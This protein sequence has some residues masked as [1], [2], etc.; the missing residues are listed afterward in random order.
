LGIAAFA[1]AAG[2]FLPP[3]PTSTSESTTTATGN[4]L[5]T[6][7]G[8]LVER[9]SILR[10]FSVAAAGAATAMINE[11]E[12]NTAVGLGLGIVG[13]NGTCNFKVLN[14]SAVAGS[15]SRIRMET[16]QPGQYCVQIHDAGDLMEPARFAITIAHS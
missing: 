10:T 14:S 5:E 7:A 4:T 3:G 16:T 6:F 9:G 2:C 12:P 8:T 1:F 11:L 15:A 13:V